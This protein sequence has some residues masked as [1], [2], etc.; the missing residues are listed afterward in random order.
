MYRFPH[1]PKASVESSFRTSSRIS[2][3]SR[4]THVYFC[5]F[6]VAFRWVIQSFP[7]IF[8]G[9]FQNISKT[10]SPDT[11]I[12]GLLPLDWRQV[13]CCQLVV[14]CLLIDC[15]W[16]QDNS[17]FTFKIWLIRIFSVEARKMVG[18]YL[19]IYICFKACRSIIFSSNSLFLAL[20]T[21]RCGCHIKTKR[22]IL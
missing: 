13:H 16:A 19:S 14:K 22:I 12:S 7:N 20:T 4:T 21:R 2:T 11:W 8:K 15:S 1:E 5:H 18:S 10:V 9:V 3:F 6:Y 17:D